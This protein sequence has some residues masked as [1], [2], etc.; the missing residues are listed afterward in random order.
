MGVGPGTSLADKV[1]AAQAAYTAGDVPGTCEI[2][3]AFIT[4]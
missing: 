2:L 4:R 1:E 3:N